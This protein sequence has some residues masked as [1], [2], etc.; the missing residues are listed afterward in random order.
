MANKTHQVADFDSIVG[1][2]TSQQILASANLLPSDW[3][4]PG[5]ETSRI[6]ALGVKIGVVPT[7]RG[8][9]PACYVGADKQIEIAGDFLNAEDFGRDETI[10]TML[11]EFGHA[12]HAFRSQ[13]SKQR[14]V[15]EVVDSYLGDLEHL[16]GDNR[17][18]MALD[19]EFFADDYARHCGFDDALHSALVKLDNISPERVTRIEE[20]QPSVFDSSGANT[21]P[22]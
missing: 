6:L 9:W 4:L 7:V 11:H 5:Y 21:K 13:P 22:H 2:E 14:D 3:R 18:K 19:E 20:S 12:V 17:K 16:F 8:A 15:K 1:D 10:A